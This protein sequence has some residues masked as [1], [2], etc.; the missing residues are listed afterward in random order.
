MYCLA[1]CLVSEML[2]V[3]KRYHDS[4]PGYRPEDG[5]VRTGESLIS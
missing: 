4:I 1:P 3:W 5:G 2:K